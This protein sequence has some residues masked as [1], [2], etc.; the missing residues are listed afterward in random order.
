MSNKT[1]FINGLQEA[2]SKHIEITM[3]TNELNATQA[4]IIAI[5]E[6]MCSHAKSNDDFEIDTHNEL[7]SNLKIY[8]RRAI[9]LENKLITI[10]NVSNR[11]KLIKATLKKLPDD[12]QTMKVKDYRELFQ[13][14]IINEDGTIDF[15]I[16]FSKSNNSNKD[17]LLPGK[18]DYV[19]RKTTHTINH[20]II[21][22]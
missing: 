8:E 13:D 2:F 17:V 6:N 14:I 5:K 21:I 10:L 19:I 18:I 12:L 15:V 4:K 1:K 20:R 7:A 11:V 16:Y 22:L 9:E 3:A